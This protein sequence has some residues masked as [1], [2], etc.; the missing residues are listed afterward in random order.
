M[1]RRTT[2]SLFAGVGGFDYAMD[3]AGCEVVAQVEKE[4]FCL[5][6]L[7]TH[8][9][10]VPKFTDVKEFGA[11]QLGFPAR[12]FPSPESGQ[13][14]QENAL[15][16]FTSLRASCESFDP[17]GLSLKMYPDFS[18]QTTDETLRKCSAFSWSNAGMGFRGVCSTASISESPNVAVE[19]LLSDVLESHVPPRF[20]LS[21]RAAA[22][23]LRRAAKRGR[24]LPS[25]LQQALEALATATG[26]DGTR[27]TL[28]E[29]LPIA[30]FPADTDTTRTEKSTS[31]PRCATWVEVAQ[32]TTRR[33]ADTSSSKTCATEQGTEQIQGRESES[34]KVAQ[35]T[36]SEAQN[37]TPL[38]SQSRLT[39]DNSL[40]EK[41]SQTI[42]Q[43]ADRP[44]VESGTK[45]TQPSPYL[46]ETNQSQQMSVRR[47]T[48]TECEILQGFPK[49]WT[50]P[51]TAL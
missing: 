16:S 13:D 51:D 33:K 22:G 25:R 35:A 45:E 34:V 49:G 44:V 10:K 46:N 37:S 7:E 11:S 42:G 15:D 3:K 23:I 5:A 32:M 9:P 1:K 30:E 21:A 27:I 12:T 48:P 50:V 17:L 6:V 41:N 4:P 19:C 20:F 2:V 8:W 24:T 39:I 40:A 18:V 36:R 38:H 14:S 43:Q 31:S 26:K 29:H 47:L 28:P